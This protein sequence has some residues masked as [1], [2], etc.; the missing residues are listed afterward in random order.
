MG[1][2]G[3]AGGQ[4]KGPWG[5]DQEGPQLQSGQPL[6]S[7]AGMA[8]GQPLGVWAGQ[9]CG[10]GGGARRQSW[11]AALH[12]GLTGRTGAG[13]REWDNQEEANPA[14]LAPEQEPGQG[15]RLARSSRKQQQRGPASITRGSEVSSQGG[16][17]T[18][19]RGR[20]RRRRAAWRSARRTV[21]LPAPGARQ[22]PPAPTPAQPPPNPAM[23]P[24][25]QGTAQM[26]P[27]SP[28]HRGPGAPW[29]ASP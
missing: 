10:A 20:H 26:R 28:S 22:S 27:G 25:G 5:P 2:T 29:T 18:S 11:A 6:S 14:A 13:S 4:E 21:N 1:G 3:R 15:Q 8:S 12:S 19:I 9:V 24:R 17:R 7:Q 23:P 16:V